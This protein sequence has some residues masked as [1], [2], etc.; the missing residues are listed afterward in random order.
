[1]ETTNAHH[2][3]WIKFTETHCWAASFEWAKPFK[4]WQA[5][6]MSFERGKKATPPQYIAS[7]NQLTELVRSGRTEEALEAWMAPLR[8]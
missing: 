8:E 7:E 5:F 6:R 2:A 1:M 4:N 3:M